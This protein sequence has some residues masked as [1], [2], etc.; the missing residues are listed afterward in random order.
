MA[1][2]AIFRYQNHVFTYDEETI[3]T[4]EDVKL[5]DKDI[6]VYLGGIEVPWNYLVSPN[7]IF[8]LIE[9]TDSVAK[10]FSVG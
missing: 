1:R 9:Q 2:F 7:M 6:T 10:L 8:A 5:Y 4:Q 3:G